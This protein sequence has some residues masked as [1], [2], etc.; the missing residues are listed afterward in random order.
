VY[1]EKKHKENENEAFCEIIREKSIGERTYGC[2]IVYL[3][4]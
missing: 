3:E 2:C 4:E 1:F